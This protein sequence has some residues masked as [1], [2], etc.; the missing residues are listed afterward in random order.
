MHEPLAAVID[1]LGPS[2]PSMNL[3]LCVDNDPTPNCSLHVV[4]THAGLT[5]T[6][7]SSPADYLTAIMD[8]VDDRLAATG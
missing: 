2:T 5:N 1:A 3:P 8:W 6:D 4:T 7:P